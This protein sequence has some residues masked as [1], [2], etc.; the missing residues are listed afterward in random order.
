MSLYEGDFWKLSEGSGSTRFDSM[1]ANHLL[2]TGG[3]VGGTTGKVGD[4]ATFNETNFLSIADNVPLSITGD[5][6]TACGVR[7]SASMTVDLI[8]LVSKWAHT[9]QRS[10]ALVYDRTGVLGTANR[11]GVLVSADG[12]GGTGASLIHTFVPSTATWYFPQAYVDHANDLIGLRIGTE[13][14]IGT[15]ETTAYTS[16]SIFDGTAAFEIGRLGTSGNVFFGD[17]DAAG[18]WPRKLEE[19]DWVTLWNGGNWS[20]PPFPSTVIPYFGEGHSPYRRI[21]HVTAY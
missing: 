4:C 14:S 20:E 18:I 6:S 13:S 10:Y 11:F 17:I 19:S 15:W 7:I 3:T 9:N 5:L 16:A 21:R 2:E 8:G 12:T 1:G